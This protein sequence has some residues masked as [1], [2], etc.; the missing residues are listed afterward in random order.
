MKRF[1]LIS[2]APDPVERM[3]REGNPLRAAEMC[4]LHYAREGWAAVTSRDTRNNRGSPE[5]LGGKRETRSSLL[6]NLFF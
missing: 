4:L 3:F 1:V 6:L 5:A 2:A